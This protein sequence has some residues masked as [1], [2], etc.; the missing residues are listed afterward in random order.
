MTLSPLQAAIDELALD[1]GVQAIV[2]LD[3]TG[4]RRIRPVEPA[5]KLGTDLGDARGAGAWIPFVVVS[6]L[7]PPWHAGTA[8][9]SVTLGLR[10]YAASFAV[11]EALYLACAAVFHRKGPRIAASRLGIYSSV[12][13]GGGTHDKDPDTR[14]PL[15]HGIVTLNVSTQ[16][17][18]V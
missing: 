6:V 2:P 17:I 9:S 16:A 13:Q 3:A 10:C 8:T 11:A 4:V 15:V 5:G 7:D 1:A 18:P 14:Q 12:V